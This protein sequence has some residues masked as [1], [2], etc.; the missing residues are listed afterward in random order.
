M[1][2]PSTGESRAE[3][4]LFAL[5]SGWVWPAALAATLLAL[6]YLPAH[7]GRTGGSEGL[8]V[9]I[10]GLYVLGASVGLMRLVRGAVLRLAG[11]REPIVL[12]GRGPDPLLDLRIRPTWRLAAI[13][14]A[15]FASLA[16]AAV[17]VLLGGLAPRPTYA[18]ALA[19]FGLVVN[20]AL[21]VG[22]LIPAP[23]FVG[24]ALLLACV[25]AAGVPADQRVRRTV[26]FVQGVVVPTIVGAGVVAAF[27][28][29]PILTL[30]SFL[31]AMMIGGEGHL[32]LGRDAIARFLSER[33]VGDL[34]RPVLTH[35]E[36][37]EAVDGLAA[38]LAGERVVTLV[39]AGG[40]LV[41]VLGPRQLAGR[42]RHRK[43][44]RVSELMIAFVDVP[45]L[46]A[47]KPGPDI[48]PVIGRYGFALVRVPG[49]LASVEVDD[50]LAQMIA[51]APGP[52]EPPARAR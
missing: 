23:G 50:V 39:E 11:S 24:W 33:I 29:S 20:L 9:S 14:G 41:G 32:A 48:L 43:G 49:G 3:G 36:A 8:I 15:T 45:F 35:A 52:T 21:A 40:A 4:H 34:V 2:T 13:A 7:T 25:D 18:H 51:R 27:L 38:R 10:G 28:G 37:I 44:Q 6:I 19:D 16:V 30:A 31:V 46:Q 5:G 47:A 26:A 12:L 17:A 1:E 22:M 42:D